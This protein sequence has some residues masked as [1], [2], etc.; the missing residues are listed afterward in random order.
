M[1]NGENDNVMVGELHSLHKPYRFEQNQDRDA[2]THT[3]RRKRK[4]NQNAA[5]C[6]PDISSLPSSCNE[7]KGWTGL[8]E[9]NTKLLSSVA[10][11]YSAILD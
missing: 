6:I 4:T 1:N 9:K 3:Q 5:K 11:I 7:Y 2:H 8:K 10:Y